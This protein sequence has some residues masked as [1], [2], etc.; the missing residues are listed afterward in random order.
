MIYESSIS[1][2]KKA[3]QD[4]P[5]KK[6]RD[7]FHIPQYKGKDMI[8]FAGNSLGLMPKKSRSAV[9]NELEI[10][11]KTRVVGQHNR[12]VDYHKH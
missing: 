11:A 1:F 2:A 9:S 5:L 12:W 8:Y 10:W 7:E 3:D 6:F 4:D